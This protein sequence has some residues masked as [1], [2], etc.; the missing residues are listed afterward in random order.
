MSRPAGLI[1]VSHLAGAAIHYARQPVASYGTRGKPRRNSMLPAFRDKLEACLEDLWRCCPLG[2]ASVFVSAGAYVDK[3]G[4]HGRGNA[5]DLD[6]LWWPR[7][8]SL[9]T[10]QYKTDAMRYLGTEALLRMHFG[11]VI[12]GFCNRAHADHWHIDAGGPVGFSPGSKSEVAFVQAA[13]LHVHGVDPGPLDREWG[14]LT[15]SAVA[16]VLKL[17]M[18]SRDGA[19]WW[20]PFLRATFLVGWGCAENPWA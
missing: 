7:G 18:V 14:P 1:S 17:D 19:A 9:I 8:E 6:A 2:S 11:T 20:V 16:W 5:I 4:Q 12:D 13:C 10:N 15:R 3:P